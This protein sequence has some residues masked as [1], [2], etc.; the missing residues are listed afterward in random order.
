M[1]QAQGRGRGARQGSRSS[2]EQWNFNLQL[3]DLNHDISAHQCRNN[4]Y[5]YLKTCIIQIHKTFVCV[6][7]TIEYFSEKNRKPIL[8]NQNEM[9]GF[10]GKYVVLTSEKTSMVSISPKFPCSKLPLDPYPLTSII[11]IYILPNSYIQ[12][13]FNQCLKS[14]N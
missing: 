2:Y 3:P 13:P 5:F 14:L 7:N 8:E 6:R 12:V 1:L 4:A 11:K 10:L 9:R